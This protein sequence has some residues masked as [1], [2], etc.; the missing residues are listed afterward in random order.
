ME[1][2]HNS[3]NMLLTL[4]SYTNNDRGM[5]NLEIEKVVDVHD[6][7]IIVAYTGCDQLLD[8]RAYSD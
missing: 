6:L 7:P 4:S 5:L 3:K 8:A 1:R 2:L